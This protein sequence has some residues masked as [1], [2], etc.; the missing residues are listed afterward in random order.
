VIF[1]L[2]WRSSLIDGGGESA[3]LNAMFHGGKR[4]TV[5]DVDVG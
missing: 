3:N 5:A 1:L 4:K 2:T